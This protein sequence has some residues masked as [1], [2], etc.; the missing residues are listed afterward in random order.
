M[1]KLFLMDVCED[2][3]IGEQLGYKHRLT[4]PRI[5][6]NGSLKIALLWSKSGDLNQWV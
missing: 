3:N 5:K 6:L 2:T 1:S 4:N